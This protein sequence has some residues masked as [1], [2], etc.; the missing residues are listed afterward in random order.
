MPRH[1]QEAEHPAEATATEATRAGGQE[2]PG[3]HTRMGAPGEGGRPSSGQRW[4]VQRM[5]GTAEAPEPEGTRGGDFLAV[6]GKVST[7]VQLREDFQVVS[8]RSWSA[9]LGP[10]ASMHLEAPCA[11]SPPAP[12]STPHVALCWAPSTLP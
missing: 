3:G 10:A 5:T 8:K 12:H 11:P 2:D 7:A 6:E 4:P 9:S 1:S